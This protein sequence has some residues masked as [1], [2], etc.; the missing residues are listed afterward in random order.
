M[1]SDFIVNL[2][3]CSVPILNSLDGLPAHCHSPR[4]ITAVKTF[5]FTLPRTSV[6]PC[7]VAFSLLLFL[8]E[9]PG[10]EP[11]TS[12]RPA[13]LHDRDLVDFKKLPDD[14]KRLLLFAL[15]TGRRN[16]WIKYQYGATDPATGGIDCSGAVQYL[17]QKAGLN[18][19][20]TS[21]DQ[22]L[23]VKAAGRLTPAPA[24][25]K[26]E[27]LDHPFFRALKPGDLLFW[28]GTYTPADG[29]TIP[30]SHVQIYLGRLKSDGRPVMIG[31]IAL[32]HWGRWNF[33]PAESRY[34]TYWLVSK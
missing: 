27:S 20:R 2:E 3:S 6:S 4:L 14:R 11:A 8:H 7:V 24:D 29:R 9:L 15:E 25:I 26:V 23:W 31:A 16:G 34:K 10:A 13:Q 19:P 33:V 32:V 5:R 18:P 12:T 1:S 30:I 17:L 21:A 22:Y 28:S